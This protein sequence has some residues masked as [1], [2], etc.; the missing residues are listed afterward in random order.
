MM[1]KLTGLAIVF[2]IFGISSWAQEVRHELTVQGSGFFN[3]QTSDGGITNK[4]TNSGGVMAGYRF[5]LK[6]WLAVEGDYD[7]FRNGQKFLAGGGTTFIPVNV[8]AATGTAIVKLPSFKAP[9]VRVVS[10]FVL[11]GGGAMF[12]DPR[13][14]SVRDVQTRATFVYGGGVDVPLSRHFLVR[15]QYRGFVYKTPDFEMASLKV[16][17]F[18]HSAVPSAGLVFTF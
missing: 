15:A 2:V 18:T 10:P 17:K 16:D 12:F 14:E 7:Y 5:N 11:A 8:H 13:G 9:G 6:N 4:P 3:K 1:K